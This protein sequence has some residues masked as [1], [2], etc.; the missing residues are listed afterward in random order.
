M[1][2]KLPSVESPLNHPILGD[3]DVRTPQSWGAGGQLG[4]FFY[5]NLLITKQ[6]I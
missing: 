3:F 5:G 1:G 2:K 4:I 6:V